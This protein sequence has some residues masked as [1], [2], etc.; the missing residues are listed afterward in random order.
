MAGRNAAQLIDIRLVEE[1]RIDESL[2][3][4][5]AR[6][7]ERIDRAL[8]GAPKPLDEEN[9]QK[10]RDQLLALL[11]AQAA[12]GVPDERL[13][14]FLRCGLGHIC[15]EL[16]AV[17]GLPLEETARRAYEELV[18]RGWDRADFELKA[19]QAAAA[20]VEEV[21]KSTRSATPRK[22]NPSSVKSVGV[23]KKVSEGIPKVASA[24]AEKAVQAKKEAQMMSQKKAAPAKKPTPKTA[25]AKKPAASAVKAASK[26]GA[27][28]KKP[29][30]AKAGVAKKVAPKK[31]ADPKTSAKKPAPSKAAV[32]KKGAVK[33]PVLKAAPAKSATKK[34]ALTKAAAKK[35][36][37]VTSKALAAKK[38]AAAKAAAA[39]KPVAKKSAGSKAAP[40]SRPL[41]VP[42]LDEKKQ[43]PTL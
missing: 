8:E 42:P 28:A 16:S 20:R 27:A 7:H 41:G 32:A 12:K 40:Q 9:A 2:F 31:L 22:K 33:K 1:K 26:T 23:D 37:A 5:Y 25:A 39:K 13:S 35:P 38:P 21:A 6:I 30:A 11:A 14:Q 10:V 15:A 19:A 3:Q 4:D 18:K 29:A 36:A 34:P 24:K 43:D 17:P